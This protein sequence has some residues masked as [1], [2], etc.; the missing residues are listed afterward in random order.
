MNLII[1]LFG[2]LIGLLGFIGLLAPEPLIRLV[3][4]FWSLPRGL[5]LAMGLRLFFGAVLLGTAPQTRFPLA[6]QIVA[7]LSISGAL[8]LPFIGNQRIQ[9]LL[10]W[11]TS[12]SDAVIRLWALIALLFGLFL[13]YACL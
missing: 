11:W 3:N 7:V 10:A 9:K 5:Y 8:A 13:V 12:R 1:I 2:V 4:R 6:L